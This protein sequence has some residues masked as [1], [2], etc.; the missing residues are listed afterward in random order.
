MGVVGLK[1][2]FLSSDARALKI[3]KICMFIIIAGLVFTLLIYINEPTPDMKEICKQS[4]FSCAFGTDIAFGGF[5][6][7]DYNFK[8]RN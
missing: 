4:L 6:L 8:K 7:L 1:K 2:I 5:L 3:L